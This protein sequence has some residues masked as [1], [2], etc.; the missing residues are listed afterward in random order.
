VSGG[1]ETPAAAPSNGGVGAAHSSVVDDALA[2]VQLGSEV[3][4]AYLRHCYLPAAGG[5]DPLH[6]NAAARSRWQTRGGTLYLAEEEPTVW[7]ESCRARAAQVVAA[8]PTGGVGLGAAN[9]AFYAVRPL[10]AP[11]DARALYEVRW[12]VAALADLTAPE[13][14]MALQSAGVDATD[15][16]ADD[17]RPCPQIAHYG[18]ANGWEAIRAPS[19]ALDGGVCVAVMPSHHPARRLWRELVAAARPTVA[20]AYLT[21]Y[22]AGERPGWLGSSA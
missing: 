4:R 9:F 18:E 16:I 21:R 8:D 5:P 2:A 14:E 12:P 13:N 10:G 20:V 19:A 15:L 1:P 6:V 11:V 3:V 17:Y 7:A 22:R